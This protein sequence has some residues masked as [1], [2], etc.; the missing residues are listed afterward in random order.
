MPPIAF[1]R[2]TWLALS[3]EARSYL[4][5]VQFHAVQMLRMA[6]DMVDCTRRVLNPV[7]GLPIKMRFG[8]H[9]GNI[10]GG[11]LGTRSFRYDIF[12]PDV[13]CA[14]QMEANGVGGGIVV[15][16]A[17]RDALASLE[18]SLYAVPGLTFLPHETVEVKGMGLV[19]TFIVVL[20]G[21][22]L[23]DGTAGGPQHG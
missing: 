21:V 17:T 14:N 2:M 18:G 6:V 10:V 19:E 22:P 9:T 1:P 12:G 4:E 20:D 23:D 13:L 16:K 8:L 15:S 7:T 5:P 3:E 11:V